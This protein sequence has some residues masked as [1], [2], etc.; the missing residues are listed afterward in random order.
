MELILL[1]LIGAITGTLAALVVLV[2][3]GGILMDFG[4][5]FDIGLGVLIGFSGAIFLIEL[6]RAGAE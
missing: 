1:I 5:L 3:P 2:K 4:T 6:M